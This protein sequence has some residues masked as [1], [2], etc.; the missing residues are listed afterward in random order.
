MRELEGGQ[1]EEVKEEEEEE[2]EEEEVEE[3]DSGPAATQQQRSPGWWVK[4]EVKEFTHE[5][6]P[7]G[8]AVRDLMLACHASNSVRCSSDTHQTGRQREA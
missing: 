6:R 2:E 7:N 5:W 1:E 8:S 4:V 3:D